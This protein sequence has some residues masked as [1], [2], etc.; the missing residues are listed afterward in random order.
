VNAASF[1]T[2]QPVAAGSWLAVFPF[3]AGTSFANVGTVSATSLPLPTSL[4]GVTVTV[5]G[6]AAPLNYVSASQIN[7][8]IPLNTAAGVQPIVVNGPAGSVSGSVRIINAA[9]GLFTK[10][11]AT[12]PQGAINNQDQSENNAN[13]P[14]IRGQVI[15]IYATG[16][17]AFNQQMNIGAAAPANPPVTTVSTP[18]VYIA[19]VPATPV[20]FSGLTPTLAGLWQIN[21][22][23]PNLPFLSGHLPVVVFMDGVDSNEVGLYVAP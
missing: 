22:T 1:R 11:S 6:T 3:P 14:A 13:R 20:S 16:A 7:L 10:D 12:P 18:E 9:P 4:G 8:L 17:G 15:T 23:V 19:G 2:D 21:V 5:G